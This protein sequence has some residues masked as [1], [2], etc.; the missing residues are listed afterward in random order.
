MDEFWRGCVAQ[1]GQDELWGLCG[2]QS[3][4]PG[5]RPPELRAAAEARWGLR[6]GAVQQHA[7]CQQKWAQCPGVLFSRL[8]LIGI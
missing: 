4:S 2:M 8:V 6:A 5:C 7:E 1:T 3:G